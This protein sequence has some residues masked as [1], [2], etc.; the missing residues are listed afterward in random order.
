MVSC[1]SAQNL[2]KRKGAKPILQGTVLHT[3]NEIV[4]GLNDMV[5]KERPSQ[6]KSV[7]RDNMLETSP[8]QAVINTVRKGIETIT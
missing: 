7:G 5:Y 4:E 3:C 2:F 6:I 1:V 8:R